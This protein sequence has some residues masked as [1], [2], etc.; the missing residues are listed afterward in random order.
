[1]AERL[2]AGL[3][4]ST[5][6]CKL[7]VIDLKPET[8]AL[9]V[10]INYDQDLPHYGTQNG[11]IPGLEPGVSES[12]PGMWTEAVRMALGRLKDAG[13]A[14]EHIRCLSVSG[15]QHGLVAL[16]A[17]G[18]LARKRSKLWNDFSTQEE[19]ALL[20]ENVGGLAAMIQEVGNSQRTGYSAAKIYHMLRHEPENFARTE[21]FLLVHNYINW[22]LAGGVKIME[23]GDTSGTALWNRSHREM[24]T[25]DPWHH[26]SRIERKTPPG[27][28]L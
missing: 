16:D 21:T 18:N 13:V 26:R 1:M 19:C 17:Q 4:V 27:K 5:Q 10:T 22:Y 7:V 14:L 20:T 15:Q 2:F 9:T 28:T 25:K 23:P 3:D 12:E 8:V 6:S 11:V 24:V